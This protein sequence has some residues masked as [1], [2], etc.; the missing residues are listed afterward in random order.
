MHMADAL[1][2]PAVG[3]SMWLLSGAAIAR[4]SA[5]VRAE[6]NDSRTPLMGVLGAFVFAAQM[7]TFAIPGTGSS[8]HLCGGTLLA[9]LLGPHAAFLTLASVLVVQALLFGDGGLLALGCNIFNMAFVTMFVVYPLLFCCLPGA[10]RSTWRM[11]AAIVMTAVLS[12]QLGAL[13]VALETCL[14]G[15]SELPL[16]AFMLLLQPIH[17]AM[18]LVEGGMTLAI[19]VFVARAR[20][21]IFTGGVLEAIFTAPPQKY[22]LDQ[23]QM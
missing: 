1:L 5:R 4:C 11:G 3:G 8:G 12:L 21:D 20:P 9:L 14:S 10:L 23:N 13:C 2:S 22:G 6:A 7:F 17:L 15:I 19:V 18:G 16:S